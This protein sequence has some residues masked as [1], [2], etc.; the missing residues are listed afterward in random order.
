M[1]V[2]EVGFVVAWVVETLVVALAVE[3]PVVALAA[4]VLAVAVRQLQPDSVPFFRPTFARPHMPRLPQEW[5][6]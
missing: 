1:P 3:A 4:G 2:L 5:K 6:L